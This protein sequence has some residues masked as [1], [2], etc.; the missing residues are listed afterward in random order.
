[1]RVLN[2]KGSAGG[3]DLPV[4][5]PATGKGRFPAGD[6]TMMQGS[7]TFFTHDLFQLQA[8]QIKDMLICK[9]NGI[10]PVDDKNTIVQT[11]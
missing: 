6:Q 5:A 7:K 8:I 1:M 11:V 10:L 2:G 3:K 9:D 4:A